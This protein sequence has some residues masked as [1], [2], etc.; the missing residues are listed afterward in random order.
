MCWPHFSPI[1][2]AHL[3][4]A[5]GTT[6]LLLRGGNITCCPTR[7]RRGEVSAI[8]PF[9][10]PAWSSLDLPIG[11]PG[12]LIHSSSC[13][14]YTHDPSGRSGLRFHPPPSTLP[15]AT[16]S[17]E[18]G[19]T[20]VTCIFFLINSLVSI[21]FSGQFHSSLCRLVVFSGSWGNWVLVIH[22]P[23]HFFGCASPARPDL[24]WT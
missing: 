12:V 21:D 13:Y 7:T 18:D 22:P 5:A 10:P 23:A 16:P 1:S 11:K 15:T 19:S 17:Q 20:I 8:L 9:D 2:A 3:L 24:T 6:A 4:A 14:N